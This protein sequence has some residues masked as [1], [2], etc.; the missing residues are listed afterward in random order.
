MI[1]DSSGTKLWKLVEPMHS[2]RHVCT[3]IKMQNPS[4]PQ[5]LLIRNKRLLCAYGG[6]RWNESPIWWGEGNIPCCWPDWQMNEWT[7]DTQIT[8]TMK[9]FTVFLVVSLNLCKALTTEW[10]A[11]PSNTGRHFEELNWLHKTEL[12]SIVI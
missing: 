10:Q 7:W 3:L 8:I 2:A 6:K 5:F 4:P 1:N 9:Y 12:H 11:C